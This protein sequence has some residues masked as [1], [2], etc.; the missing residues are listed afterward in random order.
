MYYIMEVISSSIHSSMDG[1]L[2]PDENAGFLGG[3]Y[4]TDITISGGIN[5][6]SCDIILTG[7]KVYSPSS[8]RRNRYSNSGLDA[9]GGSSENE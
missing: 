7:M 9:S 4:F 3:R 2:G 1:F 6:Q 5:H 8:N